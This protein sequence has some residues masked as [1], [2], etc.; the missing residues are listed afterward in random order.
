MS[1]QFSNLGYRRIPQTDFPFAFTLLHQCSSLP[2]RCLS[3]VHLFTFHPNLETEGFYLLTGWSGQSRVWHAKSCDVASASMFSLIFLWPLS[4]AGHCSQR[5]HLLPSVCSWLFML[6]LSPAHGLLLLSL[7]SIFHS[8][9]GIQYQLLSRASPSP[10]DS[11]VF[12]PHVARLSRPRW[13]AQSCTITEAGKAPSFVS[14][15]WHSRHSVNP[16]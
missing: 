11:T 16:D 5:E 15:P 3:K 6:I 1:I 7:S 14:V 12:S 10:P 2:R 8:L 4:C 9:I 13:P